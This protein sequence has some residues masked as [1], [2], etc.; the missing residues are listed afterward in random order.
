MM[1]GAI[2]TPQVINSK[3]MAMEGFG[4]F[5]PSFK[6]VQQFCHGKDYGGDLSI[7]SSREEGAGC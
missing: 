6:G 1:E 4:L 3:F 2:P 7:K 5:Q